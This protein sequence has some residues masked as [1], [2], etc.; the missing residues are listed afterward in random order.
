MSLPPETN[1]LKPPPGPS[2]ELTRFVM[3]R[4]LGFVYVAA[5][6]SLATQV[7]PLIGEHGLTP[8]SLYIGQLVEAS[9]RWQAF[10]QTP[11]L[12]F[13]VLSDA[14]LHGLA[15]LGVV[16]S[17]CVLFGYAN[18]LLLAV[19]WGLY[20]SFVHIGQI[21]YGY[22]WEILLCETGFLAI[23]LCPLLDG[24]PFP[25]RKTRTP[26][27]WLFRWL[28]LRVML[29]AGLIKLRG[30]P[31]WRDLTCLDFHF[32]TQPLP[33][34]LTPL[35]HFLPAWAHKG[36]VLWNHLNELIMPVFC[37]GPR[38]MRHVAGIS[39]ILFQLLLILSGNLSFLNWLT[40]V[41]LLSCL[42]DSLLGYLFSGL[43]AQRLL[44]AA[45]RSAEASAASLSGRFAVIVVVGLLALLSISPLLNLFSAQQRMNG[46]FDPFNLVNTY[47]AFGSVGRERDEI[48][49]EGTRDAVPDDSAHWL[50]YEFKCKP[51]DPLRRPCFLSPVQYRLDWQIWFAAMSDPLSEPWTLYL[52][53]KLL[54]NDPLAL[55]LLGRNPFPD[56]PPR[57]IRALRYRY[58]L[59][60]LHERA[61]WRRQRLQEPFLPP[62]SAEDPRLRAL[63]AQM[64]VL[65]GSGNF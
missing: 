23:F 46:S 54:H 45:R 13:F 3:I 44:D 29:G 62:L 9:S 51:G 32:E 18:A 15:W 6:Y 47:G 17:L 35:F 31:C 19:L 11:S 5:F 25:N 26:I 30:D 39:M 50:E 63:L 27:I 59:A 28:A 57:Y 36:G 22:G 52:V 7:L 37:F 24:R 65:Q 4:L 61:F 41:P 60:P 33:N 14:L 40:I 34:P 2:Y 20:L 53:Y 64:G 42:D 21:W 48:I 55:S 10:L 16:L 1:L 43:G 12:F 8:A 56:A 58:Q 38:P 49:F